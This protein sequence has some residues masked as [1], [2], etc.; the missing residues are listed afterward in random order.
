MKGPVADADAMGDP[1]SLAIVA[2]YVDHL[3]SEF[4]PWKIFVI[5]WE[6]FTKSPENADEILDLG[7]AVKYIQRTLH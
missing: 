7:P 6:L 4:I 1:T 5:V 3:L 2:T